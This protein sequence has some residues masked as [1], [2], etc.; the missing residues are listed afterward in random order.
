MNRDMFLMFIALLISAIFKIDLFRVV[1]VVDITYRLFCLFLFCF[2]SYQK[3]IHRKSPSS[4]DKRDG[5]LR[6]RS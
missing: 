5:R 4:S 1:A 6:Y 2:R 3:R